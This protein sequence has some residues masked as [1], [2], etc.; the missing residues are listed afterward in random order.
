MKLSRWFRRTLIV[1]ALV[2]VSAGA[3][4][5]FL[6]SG[7]GRDLARSL[8][9]SAASSDNLKI[10]IE[11][12]KGTLPGAPR[13]TK[14]TISDAQG[15]WL[16]VHDVRLQWSPFALIGGSV[17]A[18]EITADRV[19][20]LRLPKDGKESSDSDGG[21]PSLAIDK[22]AIATAV[23]APEVAGQGG[24]FSI[25]GSADTRNIAERAKLALTIVELNGGGARVGIGAHYDPAKK[26][27][28]LDA[29]IDDRAGG[30]VAT[31]LAL[32]P[33]AP[34]VV[35][36]KSEGTLD[37]WR[38]NLSGRGGT[39]LNALGNATIVRQ[40]TWRQL[41]LTFNADIVGIGPEDLRPLYEGH[42]TVELIG[43]RGDSGAWR[44]DRLDARTPALTLNG[45]GAFDAATQRAEGEATLSVP[46]GAAVA[47]LIDSAA[48][49]RDLTLTAKSEGGW[50]KPVISVDLRAA[51]VAAEGIRASALTGRITAT[52]DREWDDPGVQVAIASRLDAAELTSD[53]EDLRS[54]L[55][56]TATMTLQ[57]M[58]IEWQ[59][60]SGIAGE[61]KTT[62]ASLRFAGDAD[63]RALNGVLSLNAPS[64]A[65]A[66][67]RS[68]AVSLNATVEAN[69][70]AARWS[71]EGKGVA[72]D[73]APG[74]ALDAVLAGK[75]ESD[76][77][78][79]RYGPRRTATVVA[80]LAGRALVAQRK[81]PN[82][83]NR[84]EPQRGRGAREPERIVAR[85]PRA[86]PSSTSRSPVRP[87]RRA[88][89]AR[90]PSPAANYS[91]AR[92]RR[93]WSNS[94]KPMRTA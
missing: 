44:V 32:P 86:A 45:A 13:A 29:A 89:A 37:N 58:L 28:D 27:F 31:M 72:T 85:T 74:G 11:G 80:G 53:D 79:E 19:D 92:S 83:E 90:P 59:R 39:A 84:V 12:L 63:R 46:R 33:D 26:I 22:L 62:A 38:A 9:E 35:T 21:I 55:G 82:R 81:R 2:A 6:Q 40:G 68:G 73:V 56:P 16:V 18:E 36:L 54:L 43:A 66:G 34:L 77:R 24:T 7:P 93:Y 47:A 51:D 42:S 69:L 88:S 48:D 49:W 87:T 23:I 50:P 41:E 75:Q 1:L 15:P 64:L 67:F 61:L 94:A 17:V 3:F 5:A 76:L 91:A 57:A 65:Q 20:W 52:P 30:T 10:A 71:A 78:P 70:E 25:E 60:A 4:Y 14:V 8:I